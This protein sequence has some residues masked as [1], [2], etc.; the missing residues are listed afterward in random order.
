MLLMI[1]IKVS[2]T[3]FKVQLTFFAQAAIH[4]IFSGL[5]GERLKVSRPMPTIWLLDIITIKLQV[6]ISLC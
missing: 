3:P 5:Y 4:L 1:L 2:Y 6:V